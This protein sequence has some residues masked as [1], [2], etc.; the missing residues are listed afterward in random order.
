MVSPGSV[1]LFLQLLKP[2]Y[3][4]PF[5]HL[6]ARYVLRRSRRYQFVSTISSAISIA[7][8]L[9]PILW[10]VSTLDLY[11]R[12]LDFHCSLT[13]H[14]RNHA[15]SVCISASF[16]T[17]LALNHTSYRFL[18][19]AH[20][21]LCC[22]VILHI[23]RAAASA[24]NEHTDP[25]CSTILRDDT[26]EFVSPTTLYSISIPVY[27]LESGIVDPQQSEGRAPLARHTSYH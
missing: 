4:G 20:S 12:L 15:S 19:V 7:C 10:P 5:L 13:A 26:V 23:R 24:D 22:R 1:N 14:I 3:R 18:R 11:F 16:P 25:Q 9:T 27:E 17:P 8:I 6:F 2:N 21:V